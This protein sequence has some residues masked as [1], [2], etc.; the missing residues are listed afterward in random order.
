[1]ANRTPLLIGVAV[2]ILLI[3]GFVWFKFGSGEEI[4][5]EYVVYGV[6]LATGTEG[7]VNINPDEQPPYPCAGSDQP[8]FYPLYYCTIDHVRFVPELVRPDASGPLRMPA[9]VV[10]PKCRQ[11][12]VS[13]FPPEHEAECTGGLLPLPHWEP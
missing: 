3:A 11:V 9:T 1:M 6:C 13:Y 10:C 8:S 7:T 2:V 4:P 12:A 5:K